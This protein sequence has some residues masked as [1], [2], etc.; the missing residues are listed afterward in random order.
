MRI[1]VV[2]LGA[3]G[4]ACAHALVAC[5]I[6]RSI[7]LLNRTD[8]LARA[9]EADL[10]HAR[11]WGRRLETRAGTLT[12]LVKLEGYDL[13]VLTLGPRLY[14]GQERAAVAQ[15]SVNMLR[16]TGVADGLRKLNHGGALDDTSVLVVTNPVE[17]VVTW[18]QDQT[19]IEPLR[20]FGLG[21]TVESARLSYHLGEKLGVDAFSAWVHVLGEHGPEFVDVD[22]GRLG[23][24]VDPENLAKKKNQASTRTRQDARLIR[25]RAEQVG[26]ERAT[27]LSATFAR[28]LI[29]EGLDEDTVDL[30][31]SR[32][33]AALA[34][35]LSPGATRFGIAAA[36]AEVALAIRDDKHRVL[37]VSTR[38]P[39][40][41]RL[42]DV[43]IS[44][45]F[46][47]GRNGVGECLLNEPSDNLRTISRNLRERYTALR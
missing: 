21:T 6:A 7:A 34:P 40:R 5:D 26:R 1:G 20:L 15:R 22:N 18:L 44:L 16:D 43:A 12:D 37:T 47:L 24:L 8:M 36:V 25:W 23:S 32:L 17:I 11:A 39:P 29:D 13:I 9:V 10:G 27:R 31:R 41:L 30:V 42:D 33:E 19:G 2:G 35:A 14:G 4:E 3:L 46:A 45:P 28:E 38:P